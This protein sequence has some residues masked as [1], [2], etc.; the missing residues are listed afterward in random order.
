MDKKIEK[1]CGNCCWFRFENI[2]GFG[3]CVK[4]YPDKMPNCSDKVCKN[5]IS[6]EEKRHHLA[7]LILHNRWVRDNKEPNSG[8]MV[9]P[10]ELGKAID[11]AVEYIKTFEK[12]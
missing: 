5:F 9:N 10:T 1:C 4:H 11:F 3:N 12:I 8:K 6:N 7:V 2:D